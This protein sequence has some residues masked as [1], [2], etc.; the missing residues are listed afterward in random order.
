MLIGSKADNQ[1]TS[2]AVCR[3]INIQLF[4]HGTDGVTPPVGTEQTP[5]PAVVEPVAS[6]T[7]PAGTQTRAERIAAIANKVEGKFLTSAP[8]PVAVPKTEAPA[9][10]TPTPGTPTPQTVLDAIPADILK[11]VPEKFIKDGQIN[12]AEFVKSYKNLEG[13]FHTKAGEAAKVTQLEQ[14]LNNVNA[15][16]TNIQQNGLPPA[17][18]P[19]GQPKAEPTAEEK[20]AETAAWMN[21]FYSDPKG[22]LAKLMQGQIQSTVMPVLNPVLQT[23]QQTVMVNEWNDQVQGVADANAELFPKVKEIMIQVIKDNSDLINALPPEINKAE[24]AFNQAKMIFE[25][26]QA[27]ESMK[28]NKPIEELL[29]DEKFLASLA[30]NPE[31]K[32]LFLKGQAEQIKGKN[33]PTVMGSMQP[34]GNAPAVPPIEIKTKKDRMA[35]VANIVNRIGAA[36]TK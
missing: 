7:P 28:T 33:I 18:V 25:I 1:E 9:T 35:A 23:N 15:I 30:E 32:Q 14:Q 6:A 17:Q 26:N 3:P 19:P 2:K 16:L 29:K 12:V 11:D 36:I 24:Y 34:G 22:T 20:E 31:L 21:D 27:K 8:T 13:A 10:P 4:N 5:A